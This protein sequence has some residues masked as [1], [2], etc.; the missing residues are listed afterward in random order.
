MSGRPAGAATQ[1]QRVLKLFVGLASTTEADTISGLAH[2]LGVCERT[3]RR[4]LAAMKV[5]LDATHHLESQGG[6]VR[7]TALPPARRVA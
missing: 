4:D 3:I 1:A 6:W 2:D 5:A 7:L